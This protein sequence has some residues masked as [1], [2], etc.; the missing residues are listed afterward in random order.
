MS[1]RVVIVDDPAAKAKANAA[2]EKKSLF[3]YNANSRGFNAPGSNVPVATAPQRRDI[4]STTGSNRRYSRHPHMHHPNATPAGVVDG[5][6]ADID[7][8]LLKMRKEYIEQYSKQLPDFQVEA[9]PKRRSMMTTLA[10]SVLHA[11]AML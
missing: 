11:K 2:A 4:Y 10:S 1:K 9:K 7:V 8:F 6:M 3:S 5:I